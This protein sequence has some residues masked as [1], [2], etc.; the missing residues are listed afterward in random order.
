MKVFCRCDHC[1]AVAYHK[2]IERVTVTE[3]GVAW[4]V[5]VARCSACGEEFDASWER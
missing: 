4:L 1:G 5:T 3:G 2:V